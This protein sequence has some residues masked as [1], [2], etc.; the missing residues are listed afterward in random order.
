M[1]RRPRPR[2]RFEA[3]HG[4]P[5]LGQVLKCRRE[6]KGKS[7]LAA[8]LF[9]RHEPSK[10]SFLCSRGG[11]FVSKHDRRGYFRFVLMQLAEG[12]GLTKGQI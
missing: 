1:L 10:P 9:G 6:E 5:I 7:K 4:K 2:P 11:G 3:V 12:R 8:E